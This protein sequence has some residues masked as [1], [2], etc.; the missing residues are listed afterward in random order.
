M[1]GMNLGLKEYSLLFTPERFKNF[2][3]HQETKN[4]SSSFYLVNNKLTFTNSLLNVLGDQ[5]R[6]NYLRY[7]SKGK[8]L[9]Y[10]DAL[11]KVRS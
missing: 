1:N 6:Y 9:F 11:F 8:I 3:F 7:T 5:W 2:D 4:F 10:P